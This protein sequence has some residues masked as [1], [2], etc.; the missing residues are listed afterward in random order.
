[1]NATRLV[2]LHVE[3]L[4]NNMPAAVRHALVFLKISMKILVDE[5]DGVRASAV[6]SHICNIGTVAFDRRKQQS[7]EKNSVNTSLLWT[8]WYTLMELSS[9]MGGPRLPSGGL[10][11]KSERQR[12]EIRADRLLCR[13]SLWPPSSTYSV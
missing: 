4:A 2:K 13:Q 3:F 11:G 8:Y 10:K 5:D 7:Y 9:F 1:M 12:D 6:G